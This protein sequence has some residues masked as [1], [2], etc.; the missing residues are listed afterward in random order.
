[1]DMNGQRKD[2]FK[3]YEE[4]LDFLLNNPDDVPRAYQKYLASYYPDARVRK[5]YLNRMGVEF[6]ENSFANMGFMKVPNVAGEYKV[7]IGK[8]VSIGPN[9]VCVCEASANNGEEI[10]SYAY[11]T[12]QASAKGNIIIEDEAWLGANV[13]ILPGITIGRCSIVGAGSVVTKNVEPYTVYA[14]VP[15]KKIRN[16]DGSRLLYTKE[17][18]HNEKL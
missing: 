16:I 18:G 6:G 3:Q 17:T 2:L 7:L 13:T 4:E 15:A 9:V 5:V 8:N 10:N 14:G 1:M 11:V 12:E